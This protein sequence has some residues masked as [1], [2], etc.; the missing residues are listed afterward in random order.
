MKRIVGVAGGALLALA[1]GVVPAA[2]AT[3]NAG[4]SGASY[5]SYVQSP[6]PTADAS[7]ASNLVVSRLGGSTR[8][9][10]NLAVNKKT[11]TKGKPVFLAS[12]RTFPDALSA[13]PAASK[14]SGSLFLVPHDD[15]DEPTIQAIRALEPSEIFIIGGTG[16]VSESVENLAK[17]IAPVSRVA[18]STRYETANAIADH[19]FPGHQE[20]VFVATGTNFP[21]ALS[22][23]AGGG[24]LN[25]PV[26]LVRGTG[27]SG[28]GAKEAI[29]KR[30][31]SE[32]AIVGGNGAVSSGVEKDL[33]SIKSLSKVSRLTGKTRY[34]TNV[35]VNAFIDK[36]SDGAAKR[37]VW[38]ATGSDFPDALSAAVPAGNLHQRLVLSTKD[39]IPTD[40][41]TVWSQEV[42]SELSQVTLVG[43][44]GVLTQ[45][46]HELR[47]CADVE[48]SP[49]PDVQGPVGDLDGTI[50]LDVVALPEP[51][52][53]VEID[54]NTLGAEIPKERGDVANVVAK[55][56]ADGEE[57]EVYGTIK[58]QGTSTIVYAKKNWTLALYRDKARTDPLPLKVGG[59]IASTQ[60]VVKAE[61]LDP[62]SV[63][64]HLAYQLW[65]QMAST[66]DSN[67]QLEA[68][69]SD[70][71]HVAGAVGY[72]K[73]YMTVMNINGEHY[74]ISTLTLGHD[75]KNLNIDSTNPLHHYL[76]FDARG[77]H[78]TEK[79]W[80]KL[81]FDLLDQHTENYLRD[82]KFLDESQK[83]NLDQL[84]AFING[85]P[86]SF[87]A[88]FDT[89]LDRANTIDMLLYLEFLY[90]WDATA[91]DIQLVSYDGM[92][93]Y[94]LP[95][96]KD[97][98]F[99][100]NSGGR[101]LIEG[102]E[103]TL[104][105]NYDEED[106]SQRP[107]F[108]TYHAFQNE[109]E[110]RYAQLR[111]S[112]VLSLENMRAQA[113]DAYGRITDEQWQAERA[114][115][116]SRPHMEPG[117]ADLVQMLN[118]VETRIPVLDEHFGYTP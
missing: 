44:S 54:L 62:S 90:D 39:C 86:E 25:A 9:G 117:V 58:P 15:L 36:K 14:V 40:A 78:T 20:L 28:E 70:A 6:D 109:V 30:R 21:D 16:A 81:S 29:S 35:A 101:G 48:P 76:Q 77:G 59:S 50:D 34:E 74:G 46:V 43:G 42:G 10:T 112:G 37:E 26:L 32:V 93:W 63:R 69:N 79:T 45:G 92:K 108:R 104:L 87:E 64:N 3:E 68:D 102:S 91:L 111:D 51:V 89:H 41:V 84:G 23:S 2:V 11:A 38:I 114:A 88:D 97:T 33:R 66:R 1:M 49:G 73:T 67:P 107:W 56:A 82:D 96:D 24:A 105:L 118:W 4:G 19:F 94:F 75:P 103:S 5:S 113:A 80:D 8:Y 22:A 7:A 61:W 106:S 110:Q 65:G 55:I 115:W 72:P 31:V 53:A 98:T 47:Q 99:G 85:D 83:A 100:M 95:W 13:A 71:A 52:G 12:G 27:A 60:W 17:T 57:V 116:P 18:G